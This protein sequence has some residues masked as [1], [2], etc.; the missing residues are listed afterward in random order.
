M[1]SESQNGWKQIPFDP[2]RVPFFYGWVI[3]ATGTLGVLMSA[4]GQTVGVSVF[5]DFLLRDLD[6]SRNALSLAYCLGTTASALLITRAGR[7][8]DRYGGRWVSAGA[9]LM[10]ALV[11]MEL[12]YTPEICQALFGLFPESQQRRVTF[13]VM[14]LSFFAL[15]FS[16][17]GVLTLSSRNMVME[18][19]EKR[20]GLA[21]TVVGISVAF[22]FSYTPTFAGQLIAWSD[23]QQAWRIMALVVVGFSL[24]SLV[25]SRTRPEDHGMIPDGPLAHSSRKTHTETHVGRDFTLGEARRTFSFWIFTLSGVM[26]GLLMTAFTFH[27]ISIFDNAGLNAQQAMAFFV[28]VAFISVTFEFFGSWL[29]DY[30]RLKYLALIQLA[31]IVLVS[32]GLSYLDSGWP[33]WLA[34]LGAGMMQGMF[35]I[36]SGITWPRFYGRQHVGA[37]SGFSTSLVVLG[38]AI[39]PYIFSYV[40]SQTGSY[41]PAMMGCGLIGLSLFF[42]AFWANRPA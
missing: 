20:R 5:T 32:L 12:S 17:Q 23:W 15:R 2:A 7:V 40:H 4:P 31:G 34:M 24:V 36:V 37:I 28:P 29:S 35:G 8:Y 39:G 16:G 22:G 30:V 6:L 14:A 18:W 3:L 27:L 26:A 1:K 19:F 13:G 11:L 21:T 25:F 42:L 33:L 10:L 41:S 9:A 38:T